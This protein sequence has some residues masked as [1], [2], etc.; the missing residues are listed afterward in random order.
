MEVIIDERALFLSGRDHLV[1]TV[2]GKAIKRVAKVTGDTGFDEKRLFR[3]SDHVCVTHMQHGRMTKDASFCNWLKRFVNC[4]PRH[5]FPEI[6]G[7][8]KGIR[9]CPG[10]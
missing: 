3:T 6:L 9:K 5:N 2:G 7:P 8:E 10:V 1:V 4:G